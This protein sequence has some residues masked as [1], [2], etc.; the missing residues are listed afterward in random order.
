[1]RIVYA[2][3]AGALPRR[4]AGTI[5]VLLYG[6]GVAP[7]GA[8][9]VGAHAFRAVQRLDQPISPVA[10]D[11][12]TLALAVTAAETFVSRSEAADGWTRQLDLV[13]P[14]R[15]P[16]RWLPVTD[17]L[18][19]TLRF[20]TGDDWSLELNGWGPSAPP[21][22]NRRDS[23]H[24]AGHDGVCLFSGGLDSAI[25]AIDL[26]ARGRRPLLVSHTYRDDGPKQE[27][28][29]DR[30][31][32]PAPSRFPA[33]ACPRGGATDQ[34]DTTM[35]GRSLNFLAFAAVA[36]SA[37]RNGGHDAD[38]EI[39]VPENGFI[40]LNPPATLRRLGSLSTRTTHPHFLGRMEGIL[41]E[42]GLPVR[43]VN[44]Y[45]HMTKG[46]MIRSC[47]DQDILRRIA[48]TSVSC[49][50]WKRTRMQCGKCVPCLIRRASFHAAGWASDPTEYSD[51]GANLATLLAEGTAE[52]RGDLMALLRAVEIVETP[53][54]ERRVW[55]TGPLPLATADR[56]PYLD[57]A[58]R[59]LREVR[60]FL[61]S[62]LGRE[63]DVREAA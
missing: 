23:I 14:L 50:K 24:V 61:A 39:I 37:L 10:S 32:R 21:P 41:R 15:D 5:P 52:Q 29:L 16:A 62:E 38:V 6:S 60:D 25:G 53:E 55:L 27:Q 58:R 46:E 44:P 31:P 40:A 20:L 11:F 47:A 57:V 19:D 30:L 1:M 33:A 2:T 51:L 49:G 48:A 28:I 26:T 8:G 36:A 45:R 42:V 7:E 12:L 17:R 9:R 56:T 59:G 35:R 4:T 54:L 22:G 34:P 13:V 43:L 63:P 18:A 3:D